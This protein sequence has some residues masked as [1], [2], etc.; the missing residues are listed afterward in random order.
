MSM[1]ELFVKIVPS[2][3]FDWVLNVPVPVNNH[4]IHH[5]SL[6][7]SNKCSPW[8]F[9]KISTF[10]IA[11]INTIHKFIIFTHSPRE[12][13]PYFEIFLVRNFRHSDWIRTIKTP[14]TNTFHTVIISGFSKASPFSRSIYST[15]FLN[16]ALLTLQNKSHLPL[17]IS[18]QLL[19]YRF[20]KI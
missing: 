7:E 18:H 20:S 6:Y 5:T 2:S 17:K 13:C 14:N 9:D 15:V 1:I 16:R 10:W 8:P 19:N 11:L 3:M 4:N 12:K